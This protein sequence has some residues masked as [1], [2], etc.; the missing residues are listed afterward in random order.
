MKIVTKNWRKYIYEAL[1]IIISIL[2]AFTIDALWS[3]QTTN[4]QKSALLVALIKDFEESKT[5]LISI[6]ANHNKIEKNLEI[7]L[8]WSDSTNISEDIKIQFDSLLGT[9]FWR[10]T[11]DPPLGTLE[12]I[13]SSSRFDMIE[14]VSL[15]ANLTKW[16][17]ITINLKEKESEKVKHFYDAYYP[18][19]RKHI[20]LKDF[21]KG[22]AKLRPLAWNHNQTNAYKLFANL[23]F[24]S[25][26]YWHWVLQWNIN[27]YIP[28]VEQAI[29]DI[30]HLAQAE[31]NN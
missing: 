27:S 19:I 24:Q 2:L 11:F 10:E 9:L 26:L 5:Q 30:L 25:I 14:D 12:S 17:S 29:D 31:L 3:Q 16:P 21:D 1:V 8:K 7:L 20:S 13:I 28:E 6:K 23:E 18:Y 22:I 4:E 15:M